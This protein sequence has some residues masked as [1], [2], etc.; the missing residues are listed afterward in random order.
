MNPPRGMMTVP[1]YEWWLHHNPFKQQW[2]DAD[3]WG[4]CPICQSD[5]G[6]I[7]GCPAEELDRKLTEINELMLVWRKKL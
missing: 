5:A 7:N 6:H 3:R 4:T 2:V 1:Y